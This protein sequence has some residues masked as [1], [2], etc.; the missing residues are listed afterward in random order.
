[1]RDAWKHF[2][3]STK[4]PVFPEFLL[5]IT[6]GILWLLCNTPTVYKLM[7]G[8]LLFATLLTVILAIF[9][10]KQLST[11]VAVLMLLS[12]TN[13]LMQF[14]YIPALTLWLLC[15]LRLVQ[16]TRRNAILT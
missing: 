1:M 16:S 5:L 9:R 13:G 3:T 14:D 10:P 12:L 2:T 15:F 6:I 11:T 7:A 4:R 8:G